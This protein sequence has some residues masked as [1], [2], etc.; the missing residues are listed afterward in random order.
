MIRWFIRSALFWPRWL[1]TQ[2]DA[3]PP[4]G[5]RLP[6]Y[7]GQA[8]IEGVMMRGRRAVALAMRAPDGRIVT[9]TEPLGTIYQSPIART[10]FLRGLIALW[11]ALV[12]GIKALTL[13]ANVQLEE[14]EQ[15]EGAALYLTLGLSLAAGVGLFFLLPAAVGRWAEMLWGW[16]AWWGNLLEGV[17]RLALLVAYVGL[18]GWMPEVRRLYMYHGAEHKTINAFEAYAPLTPS[19]V[20]RFPKEHTRCGTAFLLILVLLS[21]LVFALLGPLP[22]LPRLASRILLLPLLAGVAY[23]YLRFTANH[24]ANPL[25]RLLVQPNLALQRLTTR[26]PTLDM[27]EVAITAFQ[28]MRQAEEGAP[29]PAPAAPS[30]T[31]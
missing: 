6:A 27:I 22:M 13:S 26:E 11:D 4:K 28:T 12:L 18:I 7:G 31:R 21:I 25:V 1:S 24:M 20:A 19:S 16:S 9:H 10:P 5:E 3:P 23:E 14:E 29:S 2:G 8:I 30:A 15:L 17:F